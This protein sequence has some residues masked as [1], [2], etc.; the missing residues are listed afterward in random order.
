MSRRYLAEGAQLR[1]T[2]GTS[3]GALSLL[4]RPVP[5]R[6]GGVH[7]AT[8]QDTLPM[9]NIPSFGMCQSPSNPQVASATAAAMGVL[10]PMPC[11]PSPAGP[12]SP[13]A[14]K[15]KL[16]G[17]P[18]ATEGCTCHCAW[19]GSISV[20]TAGQPRFVEA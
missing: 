5:L 2:M 17:V 1:C 19:A 7:L 8:V 16:Q 11:V 18:V 15:A 9:A 3:P 20:A 6:A 13:G 14:A 12:W 10:T 4:P